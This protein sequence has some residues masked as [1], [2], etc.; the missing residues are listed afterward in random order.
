MFENVNIILT[1]VIALITGGGLGGLITLKAQKRQ[2]D[3]Q[4]AQGLQDIYQEMLDDMKKDR[5]FYKEQCDGQR[6]DIA[7]LK[8]RVE[9]LER[10]LREYRRQTEGT[11]PTRRRRTTAPKPP[12]VMRAITPVSM[13]FTFS[14][15][16]DNFK[17]YDLEAFLSN[18]S[19]CRIL[20]LS[21][22][23]VIPSSS[24]CC[25]IRVFRSMLLMIPWSS[26]S[27]EEEP[28]AGV[29]ASPPE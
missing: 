5:D 27:G 15:I 19:S 13:M 26:I 7:A 9:E 22:R 20:F 23:M 2:A 29:L 16:S 4:A 12:P 3:N 28:A 6:A 21:C 10:E 1:G 11:P 17:V 18:F 14:N 24:S 8:R 25:S